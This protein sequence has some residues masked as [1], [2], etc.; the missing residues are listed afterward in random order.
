[1]SD[2]WGLIDNYNKYL[3][4]YLLLID[5][6]TTI[7]KETNNLE[8]YSKKISRMLALN[9]SLGIWGLRYGLKWWSGDTFIKDVW[10]FL[11][12]NGLL[13][14]ISEKLRN[15]ARPKP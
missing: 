8:R 5:Y 6:E 11:N 4:E 15:S 2:V 3:A 9:L 10:F 13:V 12:G 7:A 14:M 1:M